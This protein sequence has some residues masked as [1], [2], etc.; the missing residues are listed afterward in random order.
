MLSLS[1][2]DD[3]FKSH[4]SKSTTDR[5]STPHCP[6][7]VTCFWR[8]LVLGLACICFSSF[9][10]FWH[11][12]HDLAEGVALAVKTVKHSQAISRSYAL[13]CTTT[14]AF[15]MALSLLVWAEVKVR[16]RLY[17]N[18]LS[19]ISGYFSYLLL[20]LGCMIHH[21]LVYLL[22][23]IGIQIEAQ[24]LLYCYTLLLSS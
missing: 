14:N 21:I 8:F 12:I 23:Q 3:C 4:R 6:M 16:S 17:H 1:L 22:Y 7:S 9:S 24:A 2:V 13:P 15:T 5:H 10:C 11:R 18:Y 19:I 20:M